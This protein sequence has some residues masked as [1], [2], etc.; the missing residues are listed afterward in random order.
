MSTLKGPV[1]SRMLTVAN[2]DSTAKTN[3]SHPSTLFV[4][5]YM[6]FTIAKAI[7]MIVAITI[8][9]R[10]LIEACSPTARPP[11]VQLRKLLRMLLEIL[12]SLSLA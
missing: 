11:R 7:T 12:T 3:R 5:V 2:L 4:Y 1:V 9:T 6:H 8:T 10:G